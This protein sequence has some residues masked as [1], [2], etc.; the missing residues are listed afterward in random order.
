M[1]D[2]KTLINLS[3]SRAL[4]L[5][6]IEDVK[7]KRISRDEALTMAK[8]FESANNSIQAEANYARMALAAYDRGLSLN[9]ESTKAIEHQ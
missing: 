3:A 1:L 9:L 4:I 6:T 7:E 8:L 5:Q 2:K